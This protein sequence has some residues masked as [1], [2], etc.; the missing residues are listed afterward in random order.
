MAHNPAALRIHLTLVCKLPYRPNRSLRIFVGIMSA[1]KA[2]ATKPSSGAT[3]SRAAS[4][5]A[6]TRG[7]GRGSTIAVV[8]RLA[9]IFALFTGGMPELHLRQVAGAL[10]LQRSTVHR[11][12]NSLVRAG[13]LRQV[14]VST[15]GLG[16]LLI[17]L[18]ATAIGALR[19]VNLGEGY[20][21][22]LAEEGG[23]TAVMSI[24]GGHGPVVVRSH[25]AQGKLVQ[26]RVAVGSPLPLG[27]AQGQIF[28][29]W[30][31]DANALRRL[32]QQ[33]SP[34]PRAELLREVETVRRRKVAISAQVVEGIRTVAV[35][36]FDHE[37]VA[38]TLA[39][40]GTTAAIPADP[41]SGLAAALREAAAQLSRELGHAGI[42]EHGAIA[43]T[44]GNGGAPAPVTTG[45]NSK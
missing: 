29:A 8:E 25:E 38:A 18:G 44:P 10:G 23:E 1:T 15:Y 16:P 40:V 27:S 42:D 21:N 3:A 13:L 30:H 28:L 19:V 20:L 37:T 45:R 36:V 39:F 2:E 4:R 43:P 41:N 35:P 9:S 32:L 31:R 6:R 11:Y 26:I 34:A 24:W 12:L 14:R 7:T 33:L 5:S 17:Q 22:R